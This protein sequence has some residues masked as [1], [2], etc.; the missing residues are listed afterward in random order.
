MLF[1]LIIE[2]RCTCSLV[3]LNKI[4][5][6]TYKKVCGWCILCCAY[7]FAS[8]AWL[9]HYRSCVLHYP[10]AL[11]FGV[12]WTVLLVNPSFLFF[13]LTWSL[14]QN[15]QHGTYRSG[16]AFPLD[17]FLERALVRTQ[18]LLLH[19]C[20]W[21]S[22]TGILEIPKIPVGFRNYFNSK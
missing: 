6:P 16:K 22:S 13:S 2:G 15:W 18:F 19:I 8:E 21:K 3:F 20:R 11:L 12:Y 17:L 1:N 9:V 7:C 10:L 14:L 5:F 4:S